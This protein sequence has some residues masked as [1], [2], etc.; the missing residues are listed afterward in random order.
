MSHTLKPQSGFALCLRGIAILLLL[1]GLLHMYGAPAHALQPTKNTERILLFDST[2]N[3]QPDGLLSVRETIKVNVL[4]EKIRRGI[5]RD[6]PVR[7]KLGMGLRRY[8]TLTVQSVLRDGKP[9]PYSVQQQ[10]H[11]MRIRIGSGDRLLAHGIHT[12]QIT[13]TLDKQIGVPEGEKDA[14][15]AWNVTGNYWDFIIDKATCTIV[16]PAGVSVLSAEGATGGLGE[17]GKM[18]TSSFDASK[19]S[20]ATTRSLAPREGFTVFTRLAPPD[21]LTGPQGFAAIW[22]DNKFFFAGIALQLLPLLVFLWFWHTSGRDPRGPVVIPRYEPPAGMDAAS[23]G[24]LLQTAPMSRTRSL[25]LSIVHLAAEGCLTIESEKKK[26]VLH[27]TGKPSKI[28]AN[29]PVLETLFKTGNTLRLSSHNQSTLSAAATALLEAIKEH[30]D[31]PEIRVRNTSK[32]AVGVLTSLIA[33]AG[34]VPLIFRGEAEGF[35]MGL[36]S[37]V[38]L[39]MAVV[40]PYKILSKRFSIPGLVFSLIFF[41]IALVFFSSFNLHPEANIGMALVLWNAVLLTVFRKLMPAFTE[42]GITLVNELKGFKQFLSL[43]EQQRLEMEDQPEITKERFEAY[44]PF[45]MAFGVEREWE[46]SFKAA[47]QLRGEDSTNYG[48]HWY[49]RGF[50]ERGMH[51]VGLGAAL[52]SSIGASVA[53]SMPES[54]A[55]GSSGGFRSGSGGGSGGGSGSGGGGGGGGGW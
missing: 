40:V 22:A 3:I 18:F 41:S 48:V 11:I 30:F 4:G 9:E 43:T 45:A 19:A 39:L 51:E 27:A 44:L 42:K 5:F 35:M 14:L 16:A 54:T 26:H 55:S 8:H 1:C 15:L 2:V 32:L 52:G 28:A 21:G 12:Y 23:A 6:I 38:A 34:S 53:S 20:F 33:M 7:Y 36:A 37:C 49:D 25:M 46:N 17:H 29:Q 47:M 31:G 50:S 24:N 13:Y 10:K